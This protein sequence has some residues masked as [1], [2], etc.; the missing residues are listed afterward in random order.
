MHDSVSLQVYFA[1]YVLQVLSLLVYKE[2]RFTAFS[3]RVLT[4]KLQQLRL[5]ILRVPKCIS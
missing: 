1:G 3:Y 2:E 5:F 4:L